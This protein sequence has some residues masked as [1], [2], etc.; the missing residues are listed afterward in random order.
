MQKSGHFYLG[1]THCLGR[2]LVVGM[3]DDNEHPETV[4]SFGDEW[5][6]FDQTKMNSSE[7]ERIFSDY[8]LIFPWGELPMDA[9]GFDMGCGSGRW[10]R[11]LAGRVG[12]LNCID[13][14]DAIDVARRN[15]SDLS[16]VEFHRA[17]INETALP[18]DSQ[19]FGVVLGV[20]HHLPDPLEGLKSCV[21]M[22]KPDAPLLVYIY[23]AFDNRSFWFRIMWQISDLARR[24]I[25][26]LRP[27]AK[28]IVTDTIAL[29]V[30]FPIARLCWLLEMLGFNVNSIPLNY[31]RDHSF[32]TMR[33]DSRDR[34]G[35]PLE[36]RFTRSQIRELMELSGLTRIEFSD[37]APF[38]CAVGFK[39]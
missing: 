3:K 10:S 7:L 34:F 31:Y 8:F 2:A 5:E 16:N 26:Q 4:A 12:F 19:D 23:Y 39:Q 21:R 30:Y 38:W 37:N 9:V 29:A 18:G 20:L 11:I 27:K 14:S 25:S 36:H 33:T 17:Y 13:P 15:L 6:A 32:Y 35:T 22:L 28:Q 24:V 1:F